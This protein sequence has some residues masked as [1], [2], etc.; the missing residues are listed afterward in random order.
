VEDFLRGLEMTVVSGPFRAVDLS[1]VVQLINKT[2]QF[3][4]TT[5]RYSQEEVAVFMDQ[6]GALTLQF[7][8]LDRFGD[9]GLVSAMI[10]RPLAGTPDVLELDTWV[11]S[12]RV[13]GR[14]LEDE[15]M[16]QAVLAAGR[17]GAKALRAD[18]LPTPKNDVVRDLYP[19]LGFRPAGDPL[20]AEGATRWQLDLDGYTQRP[21]HITRKAEEQ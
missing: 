5:R 18:Y 17:L 20:P 8:L 12:C 16:N 10:L 11:M 6:E 9:N 13:F 7:R 1:R 14:Q 2:N 4:L 21:T 3:N 15:A 19:T